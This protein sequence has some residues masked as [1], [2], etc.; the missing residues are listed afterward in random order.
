MVLTVEQAIYCE[1]KTPV[2]SLRALSVAILPASAVPQSGE[3]IV[4]ADG[5]LHAHLS[6]RCTWGM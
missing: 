4:V 1:A 6:A 5:G 3:W 2:G